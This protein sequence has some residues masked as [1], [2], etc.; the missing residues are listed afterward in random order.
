MRAVGVDVLEHV[1]EQRVALAHRS[2]ERDGILLQLLELG[3]PE[4]G[5]IERDADLV[6]RRVA[7]EILRQSA[8]GAVDPLQLVDD[9]HGQADGAALVGDGARHRLADPP[10]RVGRELE[11]LRPVELLDRPDQPEVAFLDQVEQ[12]QARARVHLRDRDDETQVALDEV[13]LR[14]LVAGVLAPRELV[15]LLARQQRAVADLAHVGAQQVDV[16]GAAGFELLRCVGVELVLDGLVEQ[17]GRRGDGR[18]ALLLIGD[19]GEVRSRGLALGCVLDPL[20]NTHVVVRRYCPAPPCA[21]HR[22][23]RAGT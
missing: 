17:P 13:L 16:L 1:R 11:A 20:W 4:L 10:R 15:L 19:E 23:S 8:L 14:P 3:D 18:R 22:R 7:A 9:V 12:R 5:Q 6:V 21:R 2:L